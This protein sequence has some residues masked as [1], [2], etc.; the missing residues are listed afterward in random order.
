MTTHPL[1]QSQL[2]LIPNY[3]ELPGFHGDSVAEQRRSD[4]MLRYACMDSIMASPTATPTLPPRCASLTSSISAIMHNG[5]LCESLSHMTMSTNQH[6]RE[7]SAL[8]ELFTA[9]NPVSAGY[10]V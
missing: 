5:A 10:T 4:D 9:E 7:I 1:V 3:A 8:Y 6:C 2:V